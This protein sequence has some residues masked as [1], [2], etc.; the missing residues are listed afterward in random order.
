MEDNRPL[1]EV[2]FVAFDLETTGLF[3]VAARIVEFGALRFR[4]D[5][6]Q[7]GCLEQ[8]VDPECP[9]PREVTRIHGITDAMVRGKPTAGN[10]IPKFLAFLGGPETILLAH[11]ALFDMGFLAFAMAGRAT[12]V[13][14]HRVV[15]TLDLT[16]TCLRGLPTHRLETVARHLG[17]AEHED[18]RGLSDSRLLMGVFQKIVTRNPRLRTA[19][20]LFRLSAPLEFRGIGVAAIE[21]PRGYEELA[22]AIEEE[23]PLIMVYEGG[24]KGLSERRVTPRGLLQTRGHVYLAALCHIDGVEKTFR[25]DRIREFRVQ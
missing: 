6:T 5:G 10:I 20:D 16:R 15:D 22:V 23:R 11:N 9:I 17:V 21:P 19:G 18:H 1:S 4:L 24:T 13:P 12:S 8:L 2:E 3:P 14:L 7:L 25:L